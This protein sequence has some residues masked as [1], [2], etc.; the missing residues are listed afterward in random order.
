MPN[1]R[2]SSGESS[3]YVEPPRTEIAHD[4][5]TYGVDV[6]AVV[7]EATAWLRREEDWDDKVCP[8][9][10]GGRHYPVEQATLTL[11]TDV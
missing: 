7:I 6:N 9:H 11:S 2:M 10:P 1:E 5:H 4:V 3:E 8:A